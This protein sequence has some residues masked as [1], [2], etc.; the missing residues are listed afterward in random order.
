MN[1]ESHEIKIP[2]DPLERWSWI[3]WELKKQRMSLAKLA[4]NNGLA[5]NTLHNAKHKSYPLA[6]HIIADQL[7]LEPHDLFPER[8]SHQGHPRMNALEVSDVT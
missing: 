8:Y 6:E 3:I 2:C 4:R 7:S 1:S 5:R